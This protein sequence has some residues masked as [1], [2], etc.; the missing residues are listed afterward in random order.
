M[1]NHNM[2]TLAQIRASN[3]DGSTWL[4]ANAGSGKT[5]VLT[6]RV[7]RLLLEGVSPENILC[8]TYTKAAA[9]EM[10]NR[11]FE[12][13]GKWAMLDD[14]NLR[15]S[16]TELGLEQRLNKQTFKQARTLFAR[17][18][19]VPGSL[20]IQTIH[21]FCSSLL[22]LFPLEAGVSPNFTEIDEWTAQA[23]CTEILEKISTDEINSNS[24][25]NVSKFLSDVNL[26]DL[27]ADILK[28][29]T[30][31]S[32]FK[33]HSEICSE[34]GL[35]GNVSFEECLNK[36]FDSKD[37]K[38]IKILRENMKNGGVRDKA[39]AK[40][41]LNIKSI[42]LEFIKTL[43]DILLYKGSTEKRPEYSAKTNSF[44]SKAVLNEFLNSSIEQINKLAARIEVFR[45]TR[46]SY[47]TTEKICALYDFSQIFLNHYTN[48]KLLRGWLDF[49]DLILKTQ[50]LLIDPSIAAW[51]LY[52]LDGG[53]DHILIDEAQDT[54]P[55]Q[56][57]IIEKISQE[58]YAGEGSRDK[59]NR[60][61]F[62]V[63]DKK[64]SIYSFQGADTFELN[65]IQKKLKKRFDEAAKPLKELSLQYSFRSSPTILR[66]VDSI[67]EKPDSKNESELEN[68]ENHISFYSKLPG[69]VDLWPSIEKAEQPK[70]TEWQNPVDMPGKEGERVRLA[71]LIADQ[72]NTLISSDSLIPERTGNDYVMREISAGDFLILVQRRSVLFHE[73][74]KACKKRG[75]PIS[76]ADRLKLMDEIAVKDLI[77][78]LSFLSSPQDDLSLATVLKSPLFSWSERELFDLAHGREDRFLWEALKKRSDI[79]THEY[80]VLNN[81]LAS[82]DYLRPYELLEKILNQY[83]GR[84]NLIS[85]L[86]AEA[87]DAIDAL[88]SLSIDYEKQETPSLTGFLS[89]V[90][91]SGFEIKRQLT[92]QENQIRVMTIHGAKGL[93]SPIVILPETQKRKVELRDKILVGEKIAVWNNKKSEASRNEEEIKSKKIQALEAE[94]SRLLYVA[95]TRAETWFI[96]MSAGQLNDECWYEKIKNSLQSCKAKKQIFPTGEGLRLE[97]GNWSFEIEEKEH[98]SKKSK[99]KL[100]DWIKKVSFENK[101]QPKYLIPSDLGGSKTLSKGNGLSEEEAALHGSRV[102]KLLELL[103]KYSSQDWPEY[104]LK[105]LKANRLFDGSPNFENAIKEALSVLTD[106]KFSYIFAKDVLS[107]VPFSAKLPNL[108]NQKIYGIIDRLIVGSNNVQIIDFKTNSTVPKTVNKIPLGILRQ[109]GAYKLA[110]EEI[111][112]GKEVSCYILWTAIKKIDRLEEDLL[113]YDNLDGSTS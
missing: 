87:E 8:L 75:L 95:I 39:A 21:S 109:M 89:W 103:P 52:R 88:L 57:R 96:A 45:Q 65:R 97:E 1:K 93:E 67:L 19:E 86:G 82:I 110:I 108:K 105:M 11:L 64:Q 16:L 3:P 91:T 69:R 27:L 60:T 101:V 84:A 76:G 74:I 2:A 48:E 40:K 102:H 26:T 81:L 80:L 33:N 5:R 24:L 78:L 29:R 42:N 106:P 107:E 25:A 104:S 99:N 73:I 53:I 83:N 17:A 77:A 58:F 55:T 98:R 94:R 28:N 51:I 100:P 54:S 18:I 34:F 35:N 47:E 36:H 70:D 4:S 44:A 112:P 92:K 38:V 41:L 79:F 68:T 63:G 13:L 62:V 72:I 56:W 46:I 113:D 85:R 22:R 111:Y 61:L 15:N 14:R 59:T 49:D 32:K 9:S 90:S 30:V 20:K 66:F 23:L 43:E 37:L 6:D 7:A 10:Q 12:R 50:K 71:C 31:L